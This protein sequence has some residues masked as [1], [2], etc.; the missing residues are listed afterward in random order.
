[1]TATVTSN[2]DEDYLLLTFM[3][4]NQEAYVYLPLLE[5]EAINK[6]SLERYF[7]QED[8]INLIREFFD[9]TP[10]TRKENKLAAIYQQLENIL[11]EK[12]FLCL[13]QAGILLPLLKKHLPC[14][15]L[16]PHLKLALAF[17]LIDRRQALDH[18]EQ[19]FNL[20]DIFIESKAAEE[21]D[22]STFGVA[23]ISDL[24]K[25]KEGSSE[26]K[27][28]LILNLFFHLDPLP[29]EEEAITL[30]SS[31]KSSIEI[32]LPFIQKAF[33]YRILSAYKCLL[34]LINFSNKK[35]DLSPHLP[36]I[37][38]L[39]YQALMDPSIKDQALP[40]NWPSFLPFF[41]QFTWEKTE[42][43]DVL[44]RLAQ[45]KWLEFKDVNEKLSEE[46]KISPKMLK[47]EL[48]SALDEKLKVSEIPPVIFLATYLFTHHSVNP[49]T[50]LKKL[51]SLLTKKSLTFIDFESLANLFGCLKQIPL[52]SEEINLSLELLIEVCKQL[53]QMPVEKDITDIAAKNLS[54]IE[55]LD[56][57]SHWY[58]CQLLDQIKGLLISRKDPHLEKMGLV[59]LKSK[60]QQL[61]EQA[62]DVK[63]LL[64]IQI[65]FLQ[66]SPIR[67][68]FNRSFWKKLLALM[69]ID[70]KEDPKGDKFK[71]A[72]AVFWEVIPQEYKFSKPVAK[73]VESHT[74]DIIQI[75]FN[76]EFYSIKENLRIFFE[77]D[78]WF[79]PTHEHWHA[80]LKFN[81]LKFLALLSAEETIRFYC[82]HR[83]LFE[84]ALLKE[85][86]TLALKLFSFDIK[87]DKDHLYEELFSDEW[88]LEDPAF[89]ISFISVAAQSKKRSIMQ[90][91]WK[92]F[93]AYLFKH[94]ESNLQIL[95]SALPDFLKAF[96]LS[97]GS[98]LAELALDGRLRAWLAKDFNILL[99]CLNFS[100]QLLQK[101]NVIEPNS[102]FYRAL[103][104]F[105]N[106]ALNLNFDKL[107]DN[108]FI[109][110]AELWPPLLSLFY[111]H[112]HSNLEHHYSIA[113]ILFDKL[114]AQS[115]QVLQ[116]IDFIQ[117]L[118]QFLKETSIKRIRKKMK[119]EE[120]LKKYKM[121]EELKNEEILKQ[122]IR[123]IEK[124]LKSL[125]PRLCNAI[126]T[127]TYTKSAPFI[128]NI[129]AKYLFLFF[130]NTF[131]SGDNELMW[132]WLFDLVNCF[133]NGALQES[134][135]RKLAYMIKRSFEEDLYE[136]AADSGLA[137][138]KRFLKHPTIKIILDVKQT[139]FLWEVVFQFIPKYRASVFITNE[140]LEKSG[141]DYNA[142]IEPSS[143][144]EFNKIEQE[145]QRLKD[146]F[147]HLFDSLPF[148]TKTMGFVETKN[149]LNEMIC[150][151]FA[152]QSLANGD[153]LAEMMM[154]ELNKLISQEKKQ[155]WLFIQQKV[156]I[157]TS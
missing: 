10:T 143:L 86:P 29:K 20:G 35:V 95:E 71:M 122:R 76:R 145:K 147:F 81:F 148:L 93:C 69:Q 26:Y 52:T 15:N 154:S 16:W 108:Q 6:E 90:N 138:V 14:F 128:E 129:N 137:F 42:R 124:V 43:V 117:A 3:Q 8:G 4:D 11:L 56:K 75:L 62:G 1:M 132:N 28:S 104:C 18:L 157:R 27:Q 73:H 55:R 111:E 59:V 45:L 112:N 127:S 72:V 38:Q 130:A 79:G 96:D 92:K 39:F 7:Q 120:E 33:Q 150:R 36:I 60:M 78:K 12:D 53:K 82:Q 2:Q 102:S 22:S 142:F 149:F 105:N 97:Y 152:L 49:E 19:A 156:Q 103:I 32:L 9:E 30:L 50:F 47:E 109:R 77:L 125:S 87:N 67:F 126:F 25:T 155:R 114:V 119:K 107:S 91:A 110:L 88:P 61:M 136:K 58:Y 66:Q 23:F 153:Y 98:E 24:L 31:F 46:L 17:A 89:W 115:S 54:F 134:H 74:L 40:K 37:R 51:R 48:T 68:A 57:L 63:S 13:G 135:K 146:F 101:Q 85:N 84:T 83:S 151:L 123:G 141:Y 64:E 139:F 116:Q 106:E 41:S 80:L 34:A 70:P 65:P 118:N 94:K 133:D 113:C 44:Y 144:S 21:K 121:Q 5:K 140:Q 131:N 100:F 99:D